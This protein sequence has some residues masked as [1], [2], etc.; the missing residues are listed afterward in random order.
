MGLEGRLRAELERLEAAARL[1]LPS[2]SRVRETR[3][4]WTDVSSNDYLGLGREGVSRETL[5]ALA[6]L[7]RG[8]G[9]SRLIH[10]TDP[11]HSELEQEL[12]D[13]VRL[14]SALLFASGYAANVGLLSSLA[15]EGDLI[16]SD[17]LNHASI[18]DGCRLS[19][20]RVRVTPH[21]DLDALERALR[22]DAVQRWVVVESYYSMDGDSPD[23]GALR[24][25]CDRYDAALI[26][27]EAHALGVFGS[28][29]AGLCAQAGIVPDAL[30]GT[31]GKA[32]GVQGAFVAGSPLL[33]TSLWNRARSFVFSTGT[34]PFLAGLVQA[35]VRRVRASD[36]ARH[37]LSTLNHQLERLLSDAEI[38]LP[39]AR[40]G[41]LFPVLLGDE[42]TALKAAA[43]LRDRGFLALAIRPPTV[44]RG[45]ARL[46]ITLQ[47]TFDDKTVR[48][49]A[50]ALIAACS[51][52]SS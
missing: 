31:L 21:R 38:A 5:D 18:I 9:A 7:S 34:S 41:P 16:V 27:D 1:R 14:P 23:L 45:T 13:W 49:L 43:A 10:G 11:A 4:H 40:H 3:L 22:D 12:A 17:A 29:G 33:V 6:G 42:A 50:D 20:A 15:Q 46:R 44:P 26:V 52:S 24:V 2:D 8:A 25:L 37:H 28:Q 32:V 47:S 51:E 36:A 30:V 48:A 35:Q 19:R 39:P